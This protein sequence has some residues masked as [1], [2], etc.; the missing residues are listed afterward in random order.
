[1]KSMNLF[2]IPGNPPVE[3]FYEKWKREIIHRH[4]DIE[5]SINYF[6]P[7][8]QYKDS[9]DYLHQIVEFYQRRFERFQEK[10]KSKQTKNVVIGHSI[11]GYIALQ[12]TRNNLNDIDQCGLLFPFLQ[13]PSL[14]GY[15][16]LNLISSIQKRRM[17]FNGV[18]LAR[19]LLQVFF[20]ELAE[21]KEN[22]IVSGFSFVPHERATIGQIVEPE[23]YYE[24]PEE[25]KA[26]TFAVYTGNDTWYHREAVS[27]LKKQFHCRF[28]E[29]RHDFVTVSKERDKMWELL[30]TELNGIS[31]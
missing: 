28:I 1:M 23:I 3:S 5:V 20:R 25:L 30:C 17:L 29:L 15:L 26:K 11:G 12:L 27:F 19:P 7:I 4:P 8:D 2:I 16:V 6:P 24:F 9:A 22:E 13:R 10:Q 18:L 31:G 21:V 14:R